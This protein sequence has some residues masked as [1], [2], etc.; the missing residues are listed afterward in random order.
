MPTGS[1]IV[2]VDLYPIKPIPGTISIKGDITT[3]ELRAELRATIHSFKA[4]VVL[5]DG[6]PNVG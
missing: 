3:E 4:D 6:A 2:G 5:H 1:L